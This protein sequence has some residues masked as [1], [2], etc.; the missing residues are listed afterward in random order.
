MVERGHED[1]VGIDERVAYEYAAV[2]R[3]YA[4]LGIPDRTAIEFFNGPHSI[5]G[6]GTIEFLHRWLEWPKTK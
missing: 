4:F 5:H 1:T 3:F 2:R 6:V